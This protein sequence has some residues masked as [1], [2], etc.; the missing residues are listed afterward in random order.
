M[1]R[2]ER[3]SRTDEIFSNEIIAKEQ[4]TVVGVGGI[5]RNVAIQLASIGAEHIQLIDF[6]TVEESNIATQGYLE[7]DMNLLKVEA[8]LSAIERINSNVHVDAVNSRFKRRMDV[9]NIVFCC[10][11]KMDIR[12]LIFNSVIDTTGL[13]VDGR[14]AAENLKVYSVPAGEVNDQEAY[15]K[16]LFSNEE[17]YQGAC[18]AK[19]T[20][21]C[22]SIA[23]GIMVSRYTK[24]VRQ[25]PNTFCVSFNIFGDEMSAEYSK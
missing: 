2:D 16:T 24:F 15:S 14:M 4:F 7:K 1:N 20:L 12:E 9:G 8:T 10:V 23:A 18:T 11:D 3:Y 17:M 22:A 6:D 5:G 25:I 21:Y 13:F 19:S